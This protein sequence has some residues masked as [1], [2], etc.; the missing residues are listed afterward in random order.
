MLASQLYSAQSD[1]VWRMESDRLGNA[2]ELMTILEA[3][4]LRSNAE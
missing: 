1:F 2:S 4:R 3:E